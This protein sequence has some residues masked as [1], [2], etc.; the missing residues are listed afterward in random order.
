M[1]T[2]FFLHPALLLIIGALILPFIREPFRKPYLLLVDGA[3]N[4]H[5]LFVITTTDPGL[6]P[7]TLVHL[8]RPWF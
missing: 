2:S 1:T 5:L 4:L 8:W 7:D 6:V 3:N